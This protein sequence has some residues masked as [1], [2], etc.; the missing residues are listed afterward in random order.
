MTRVLLADD[1]PL[2]RKSLSVLLQRH[3]LDV[4]TAEDG[5]AALKRVRAGRFEVAIVDLNMP[6]MSGLDLIRQARAVDPD[7]EV[8]VVTGFGTIENA[9][10]AIREGASDYVTKPLIDEELM[11][12]VQ[13]AIEQHRL[14]HENRTMREELD[15]RSAFDEI[16]AFDERMQKLFKVIDSVAPTRTTVLI[17]GES[18]TGKTMIAR[19]IHRA[20]GRKDAPFVEVNC[21]A[22]PDTLLESELFGHVRGAFTGAVKDRV[23]KFEQAG[24]GTIFLDEIGTAT[25]ALQVKL[26]RVLQDRQVERVGD[27]RT[28]QVDVRVILAT[29]MDLRAMV[30]DG[31]FREDLFYRIN[32]VS[33][34]LAPLRERLHDIAP[35]ARHFLERFA[36]EN[37]KDVTDFSPDAM[38]ALLGYPWPGNVREL[39]NAIERAVVLSRKPIIEAED[40]PK[41]S[42]EAGAFPGDEDVI[43]PLKIAIQG[44][45]KRII[46]KALARNAG[47]RQ[48]TAAMLGVNRTTLF[49][50]MKKYGLLG[51]R[52]GD[53]PDRDQGDRDQGDPGRGGAGPDARPRHGADP[54]PR[55]AG[56]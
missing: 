18:G 16:I 13:R 5:L 42:P 36:R 37:Q 22:L 11:V 3:S 49:N 35:L 30:R 55:P 31:R 38:A 47:N 27:S 51:S 19:A 4:E 52:T 45:E 53:A 24:G 10:Q 56:R 15:R 48:N 39:E 6:R 8:I 54:G 26:L 41:R 50:K 32:V 21:G 23:G 7:L 44:P 20:S 2:V 34:D 25:P 28:L 9:V 46:E 33:L 29:N 17:T 1:D 43:L 40:L 12:R 14:R